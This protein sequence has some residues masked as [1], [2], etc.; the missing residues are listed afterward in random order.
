[1]MREGKK[2]SRESNKTLCFLFV[3][4]TKMNE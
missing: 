4:A 2:E 3:W 1:V